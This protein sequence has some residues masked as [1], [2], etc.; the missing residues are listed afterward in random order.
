MCQR[1]KEKKLKRVYYVGNHCKTPFVTVGADLRQVLYEN[2]EC[3]LYFVVKV[4]EIV[5]YS[6]I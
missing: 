6:L 4:I 5:C 3:P 1:V 2:W